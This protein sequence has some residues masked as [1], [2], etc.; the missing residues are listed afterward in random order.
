M[1]RS[2]L[3]YTELYSSGLILYK[4]AQ[5]MVFER[6]VCWDRWVLSHSNS[7]SI[8]WV[9]VLC[10]GV[11]WRSFKKNNNFYKTSTTLE[12]VGSSSPC[13]YHF[14][15]TIASRDHHPFWFLLKSEGLHMFDDLIV[16]WGLHTHGRPYKLKSWLTCP[17]IWLLSTMV[18]H[19]S[20]T[21]ACLQD[22]TAIEEV[23]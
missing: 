18:L 9:V 13:L 4:S 7:R 23:H 11:F 1:I 14:R 12:F 5:L 20:N 6:L 19:P 15:V 2:L 21:F 3:L 17:S 16:P 22:S 8:S 10:G